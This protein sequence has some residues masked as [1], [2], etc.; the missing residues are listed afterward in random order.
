[1]VAAVGNW[2]ACLII[3]SPGQSGDPNSA[4]YADHFPLWVREEYV[5]LLFSRQAI[6]ATTEHVIILEPPLVT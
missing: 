5:P 6:D 1:M 4:H 2:D 3:N